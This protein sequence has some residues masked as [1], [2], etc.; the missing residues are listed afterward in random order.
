V[1]LH[2][3]SSSLIPLPSIV[4]SVPEMKTVPFSETLTS[5]YDSTRRQN[6]EQII[7]IVIIITIT[8]IKSTVVLSVRHLSDSLNWGSRRRVTLIGSVDGKRRC[9]I[10][11]RENIKLLELKF[12]IDSNSSESSIDSSNSDNDSDSDLTDTSELAQPLGE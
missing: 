2:F 4:T 1:Q 7:I 5:S 12:A 6:P 9:F 11:H 8:I 3:T 10:V